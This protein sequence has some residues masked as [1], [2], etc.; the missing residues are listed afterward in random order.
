MCRL[1][2]DVLLD[3]ITAL[4]RDPHKYSATKTFYFFEYGIV[5]SFEWF[6]YGA[7]YEDEKVN[8]LYHLYQSSLSLMQIQLELVAKSCC[9]AHCRSGF[10]DGMGNEYIPY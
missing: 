2:D 8:L 7:R 1:I 9:P 6:Y 10:K 5:F 3:K 4:V